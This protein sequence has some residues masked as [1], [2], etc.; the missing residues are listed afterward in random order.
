VRA[1]EAALLSVLS[2]EEKET[3]AALLKKIRAMEAE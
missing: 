1:H 3:L 2:A